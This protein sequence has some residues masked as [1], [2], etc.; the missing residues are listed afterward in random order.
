MLAPNPD[1]TGIVSTT[2][3]VVPMIYS[4]STPEIRAHDGWTKIGY[5]E[6][7]VN[8]RLAQ[9]THTADVKAHEEWRGKAEFDD[10]SGEAFSDHDFHAYLVKQGIERN[11]GTEWFH[12]D[13]PKGHNFFYEFRVNRGVLETI[14]AR[15]YELRSEQEKAI[16]QTRDYSELHE[17]G[18]FLWNAKPRFGKTLSAYDFCKRK[19]A[20]KILIVT[21]RPAIA[22]SWYDDYVRFLGTQSG[23]LFVSSVDALRGQPFVLSREQYVDQL[24]GKDARRA[25]IEFVSLQDLKGSVHFGGT[26]DKLNEV[27]DL[28]WDV[29]IIDEAHEGVDT[30]KS[31]VAFDH[32]SRKFTLHLSGTPFKAIANEKFKEDAIFNWTYADEQKA[33]E[34]WDDPEREN[35]YSDLPK[36]NLFTYQ[37]SDVIEDKASAGIDIEGTTEE[38]AFDLNEFFATDGRTHFAHHDDVRRFLDALTTQRKYPFSTPALRNELKHTLWILNRVDSAKALVTMLKNHPV[39]ENYEIVLAAGDGKVDDD[40]ANEKS[41]DK[42]RSAIASYEKTITISVGQLTTG[43]T[44]PEWTAVLMLSN[45]RS[46]S[47]YM[48]AAFRAQNPCLFNK[49]G[50]FFRKENA[51]VFD[52]DPARTL[53]IFEEFANDLYSDTA[54]GKGDTDSR[55]QRVRTLLN[56]LPVLGEDDNGEMV[57]LD[58]EEV[59]SIPRKIRSRE[60]VKRGFMSDFLFQNISN[61]FHAPA[62]VL[63]IIEK[64]QPTKEPSHDL[65]IGQS[66]S[67]DLNLDDNG[68]VAMSDEQVIGR[69]AE[70]FGN[71]VYDVV[72]EELGKAVE[73]IAEAHAQDDRKD[74]IVEALSKVFTETTLTPL[75]DAAREEY[76]TEMRPSTE[77]HVERKIKEDV[78]GAFNRKVGDYMIQRR[79]IELSREK[80]LSS[81]ETADEEERVNA[82]HDEMAED[83]IGMLKTDL[84]ASQ[85]ELIHG[86]GEDIV[87]AIETD[88]REDKKRTIENGVRDHLRG[89]SRTIPSFLM[90]YG[91]EETTLENF[92]SVIP[93]GVFKDVTSITIDEFRF[94]RDG[95]DYPDEDTGEMRH[96]EGN[97]F[98]PVVFN[99]SVKEFIHLRSELA[100]YFNEEQE[101]DIF[102]YIPPQTTFQIFTPKTVVQKMVDLF[103]QENPGCFD[104]PDHTFADLY[105]KSGLYITEIVKRLYK[106]QKMKEIFPNDQERLKHIFETQV[107]GAAPT[108]II[109]EIATHYILGF[110]NEI[111]AGC[112]TNFVLAD[113]AK[114]A[115]EGKL[116]EF[117][118]STFGKKL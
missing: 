89:F 112:D 109:F 79:Q 38:Y 32:I 3:P 78:K 86:A 51:Y 108:K 97:L 62:S 74:P 92:D 83:A 30:Y 40:D 28:I 18:E 66:T 67:S 43:V 98:D 115:Q 41:F 2:I 26:Y 11:V 21:N 99:D 17:Q 81:A 42:V 50:H 63:G 12:V 88:K 22:N 37:M 59:L 1:I 90:A 46:P 85:D 53:T 27:A 118:N 72:S 23:Y 116:T 65:V 64:F 9:Q 6:Q 70:L 113:T 35:P 68:N 106:S 73:E 19:N 107:F 102:D 94:L 77:R 84:F 29:L 55:K 20:K 93:G 104:N 8:V 31:D 16:E 10:G 91:T 47:L 71:K 76:G 103:E 5:T 114:L 75:V 61:V 44:I 25:F 87:R 105:M 80:A 117:V 13:G 111:G 48:Q 100:D 49:D 45:M 24:K 60:V 14:P 33:K 110:N 69:S 96:F 15:A 56:F 95:G 58:A 101:G 57:E 34:S 82:K 39:F 54:A 4:Y 7:D 36:L 52:F